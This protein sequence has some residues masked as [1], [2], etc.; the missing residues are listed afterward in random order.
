MMLDV[1]SAALVLKN[2]S[3]RVIGGMPLTFTEM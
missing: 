1:A 2:A 3:R